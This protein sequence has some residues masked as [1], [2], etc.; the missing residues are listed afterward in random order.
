[1]TLNLNFEDFGNGDPLLILHGL[2]GSRRNWLTLARRL[3][4][5]A[6]VIAVDLRNHGDSPHADNMDYPHM[7]ADIHRLLDRLGI[8]QAA[9]VGHSMGGK[10]AMVFALLYPQR[11]S[12]LMAID[13]AP[14]RYHS[15]FDGLIA[16][17]LALPVQQLR[18][19]QHADELLAAS[20][21]ETGLRQFLLHNLVRADKGFR[22]RVNLAAIR[23]A[24]EDICGF[25]DCVTTSQYRGRTRF[26]A[27]E[28]SDYLQARH[29]ETVRALF[30]GA[31]LH[32]VPDSGHWVHADQP[33]AV[34]DLIQGLMGTQAA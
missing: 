27:G 9:V 31:E 12:H 14:T 5:D 16:A 34:I 6:R 17:M 13:I 28:R 22:W 10:V 11:T 19:R 30:P 2:F 8:D 32:V 1:M 29:E 20:V 24:M 23:N 7:A 4:A 18:S 3:A 21:S 26:V 33:Q 15:E 25:P